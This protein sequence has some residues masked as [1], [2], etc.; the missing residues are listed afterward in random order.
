MLLGA[1]ALL[2]GYMLAGPVPAATKP[3]HYPAW[4]FERDVI[5]RLPEEINNSSPA[6]PD[7]YPDTD[8]FGVANIGQLKLIASKAAEEMDASHPAL[9]I[10]A[11]IEA[12]VASWSPSIT[13]SSRDDY[14]VLNQGQ[15]KFVATLFYDRLGDFDYSGPPLQ[16]GATYPWTHGEGQEADDDAFAAV[17]LGQLKRVFSFSLASTLAAGDGDGDGLLDTWE[18]AHFGN[19]AEDGS[20]DWNDDGLLDRD[21]FR[22]GLDPKGGDESQ[23]AGK[24][25][26]F[27]YDAR[28]WLE[29]TT[30]TGGTPVSYTLDTEGNIELFQ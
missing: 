16:G 17:N 11:D 13:N 10:G 23:V 18:M 24:F 22:F 12:L 14:A 30:I 29:G 21:A 26:V 4:W 5:K 3:E 2:P 7:D 15:L 8:D 6:W 28:G 27:S 9:G 20:G 25:D 1:V 19:L